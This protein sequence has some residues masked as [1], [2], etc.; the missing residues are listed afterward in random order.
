MKLFCLSAADYREMYMSDGTLVEAVDFTEVILKI[1]INRGK[2]SKLNNTP[3]WKLLLFWGF[4]ITVL[5][6][7]YELF[8]FLMHLCFFIQI[9]SYAVTRASRCAMNQ[10]K[11]YIPCIDHVRSAS[12]VFQLLWNT[13]HLSLMRWLIRCSIMNHPLI[14]SRIQQPYHNLITTLADH[15]LR[16]RGTCH[17]AASLGLFTLTQTM[18]VTGMILHTKLFTTIC[19]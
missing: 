19:S 6:K 4:S 10:S 13:V 9:W 11:I 5:S 8:L 2:F 7:M 15:V 12:Y 1:E 14:Y 3:N 16:R 17:L 18:A